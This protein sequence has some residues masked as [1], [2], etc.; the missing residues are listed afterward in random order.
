M[1][2]EI[3]F[4]LFTKLIDFISHFMVVYSIYQILLKNFL[5][6]LRKRWLQCSNIYWC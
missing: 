1:F 5:N 4:A 3:N 6:Q 2:H